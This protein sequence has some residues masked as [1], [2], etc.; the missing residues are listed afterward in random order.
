MSTNRDQILLAMILCHIFPK[1]KRTILRIY[2]HAITASNIDIMNKLHQVKKA[3][4]KQAVIYDIKLSVY[5]LATCP[6]RF[7][8]D[9]TISEL[10]E[11]H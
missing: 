2:N 10:P 9:T 1:K 7:V 6:A 5:L 4:V 3:Q 8:C 11:Y